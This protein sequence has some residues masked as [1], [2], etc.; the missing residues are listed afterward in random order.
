MKNPCDPLQNPI[1]FIV[2]VGV[3]DRFKIVDIGED[4]APDHFSSSG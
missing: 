2:T 4:E 1:T 3:I